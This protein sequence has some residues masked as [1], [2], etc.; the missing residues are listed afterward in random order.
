[1]EQE[2]E[3]P[4]GRPALGRRGAD[5]GDPPRA[6]EDSGDLLVA[7]DRDRPAALFEVEEGDGPLPRLAIGGLPFLVGQD[8]PSLT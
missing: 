4:K 5:D 3:H 2:P 7:R 6:A 8:A 1:V